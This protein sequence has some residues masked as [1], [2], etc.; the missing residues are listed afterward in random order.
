MVEK[1]AAPAQTALWTILSATVIDAAIAWSL[2]KFELPF[3]FTETQYFLKDVFSSGMK[4]C[5]YVH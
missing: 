2:L 4:R 1:K 3:P 5:V